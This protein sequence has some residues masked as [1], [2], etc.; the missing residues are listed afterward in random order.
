MDRSLSHTALAQALKA[1]EPQALDLSHFYYS[2]KI[3]IGPSVSGET[4]DQVATDLPRNLTAL[5]GGTKQFTCRLQSDELGRWLVVRGELPEGVVFQHDRDNLEEYLDRHAFALLE[6]YAVPKYQGAV[7]GKM[8]AR[9]T[10]G[11][12]IH[13]QL[14]RTC[15][16]WLIG[17]KD[18][19]SKF[20]D[21]AYASIEP[22]AILH[23]IISGDTPNERIREICTEVAEYLDLYFAG[24]IYVVDST[25]TYPSYALER[26][27]VTGD[28]RM[29][30]DF[31]ANQA[32]SGQ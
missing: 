17:L 28:Y 19:Q 12:F 13:L 22:G 11:G 24:H 4:I 2:A 10:E 20:T 32:S 25:E 15:G 29:W 3:A 6:R 21:I 18:L 23:F 26:L 16:R 9:K 1:L 27:G 14:V 7:Y 30:I 31:E 5:L 8:E